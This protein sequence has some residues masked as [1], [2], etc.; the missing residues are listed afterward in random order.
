MWSLNN[1]FEVWSKADDKK[2]HV[3]RQADTSRSE[4]DEETDQRRTPKAKEQED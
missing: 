4:G 3:S 2:S 1:G